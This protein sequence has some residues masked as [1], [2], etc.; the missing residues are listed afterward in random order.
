MTERTINWERPPVDP[1]EE[2][3]VVRRGPVRRKTQPFDL[4]YIDRLTDCALLPPVKGGHPVVAVAGLDGPA[5]LLCLYDGASGEMIQW[6]E[7]HSEMI[8]R[9]EFS[10]DGKWLVSTSDDRT[11]CLWRIG[12][13]EKAGRQK[14]RGG[15]R[16]TR[17]RWRRKVLAVNPRGVNGQAKRFEPGDRIV[18]ISRD[19]QDLHFTK[20]EDL[21]K[22]TQGIEGPVT[23]LIRRGQNPEQRVD[24]VSLEKDPERIRPDL[25][26]FFLESKPGGDRALSWITWTA[27]GDYDFVGDRTIEDLLGWHDNPPARG[28]P[29]PSYQRI[30]ENR[31]KRNT[32]LLP[33][34]NE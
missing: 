34:L 23:V 25:S 27:D 10:P 8:R 24:G 29:M 14:N 15:L 18:G 5:P 6:L 20:P 22:E 3:R 13:V 17:G 32:G 1:A 19:G 2:G 4:T 12:D 9:L 31:G 11:V 28:G 21:L 26:L 33:S 7:G 16:H 30:D